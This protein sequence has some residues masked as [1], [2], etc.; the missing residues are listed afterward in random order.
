MFSYFEAVFF[1]GVVFASG[2]ADY[3]YNT[4]GDDW[5]II[6]EGKYSVCGSG[7]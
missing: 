7:H 4:N 6:H 3:D 2:E 5:A 1:V